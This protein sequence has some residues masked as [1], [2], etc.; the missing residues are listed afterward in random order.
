VG[1]TVDKKLDV[2]VYLFPTYDV[3]LHEPPEVVGDLVET[4]AGID[5]FIDG[6]VLPTVR[7]L[8]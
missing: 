6:R 3:R 2:D 1:L 4:L 5:Q 7:A 8:L